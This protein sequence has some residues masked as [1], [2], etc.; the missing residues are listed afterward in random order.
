MTGFLHILKELGRNFTR[1]PGTALGSFLS[2]LLLFLL[3]ELYWVSANTAERFYS[4]LLSNLT[5][6]VFLDEKVADSTLPLLESTIAAMEGVD[7]VT[8]TSKEQ[9]R[10]ELSRLIGVDLLVGYDTTNPLPRSF[11]LALAAEHV[12]TVDVA[13]MEAEIAQLSGVAQVV[14][15]KHWLENAESVRE[16]MLK[17]GVALGA[18]ILLTAWLTLMNS[19][20]LMMQA[21]AA[22]LRQL[23]LLGAG[24]FFLSW[25]FLIEGCLIAGLSAAAGWIPILYGKQKV[26]FTQVEIVTPALDDIAIFCGAVAL[27]GMISSYLGIR[28]HLK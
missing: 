4:H 18:V 8:Y 17:V 2:L 27:L 9:A 24:K 23:R 7:S 22:G 3:F 16:L 11:T 5:M 26:V 15:S 25:P 6:E 14:Y 1:H 12:N 20:R 21:R 13:D 19:I 10:D 28:K